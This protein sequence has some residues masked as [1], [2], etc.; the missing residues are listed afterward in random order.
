MPRTPDGREW[1]SCHQPGSR[2]P[3]GSEWP[4]GHQLGRKPGRSHGD[5]ITSMV[6]VGNPDGFLLVLLGAGATSG[7]RKDDLKLTPPRPGFLQEGAPWTSPIDLVP[8]CPQLEKS[9]D[10][11]GL[12]GAWRGPWVYARLIRTLVDTQQFYDHLGPTTGQNLFANLSPEPPGVLPIYSHPLRDP[13]SHHLRVSQPFRWLNAF[14]PCHRGQHM[15]SAPACL[16]T[17]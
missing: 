15:A 12:S 8:P 16:P 1:A 3:R 7:R 11:T 10:V 6:V 2:P 4:E 13:V 5:I 17:S 9:T 14:C